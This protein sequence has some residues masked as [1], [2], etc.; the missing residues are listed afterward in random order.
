M[1]TNRDLKLAHLPHCDWRSFM[2]YTGPDGTAPLPQEV[3]ALDHYFAH[4]VPP[5]PCIKCGHDLGAP[6]TLGNLIG[7]GSFVWG[8]TN[9]EG[10]CA[11]GGCS[12]PA[13][14]IHRDVGPIKCLEFVLQYHPDIVTWDE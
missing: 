1:K 6:N 13:R 14:A 10:Q 3:E 11:V 7:R 4:F 5:G 8:I 9:G 12:W 2:S